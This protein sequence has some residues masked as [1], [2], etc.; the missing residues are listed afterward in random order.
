MIDVEYFLAGFWSL[1]WLWKKRKDWFCGCCWWWWFT[2]ALVYSRGK[3]NEKINEQTWSEILLW[4][5]NIKNSV[6]MPYYSRD[7]GGILF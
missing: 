7:W 1:D 4:G 3:L 5:K 2:M 6:L